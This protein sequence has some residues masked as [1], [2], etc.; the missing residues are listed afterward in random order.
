LPDTIFRTL[1]SSRQNPLASIKEAI[2]AKYKAVDL[3]NELP[4]DEQKDWNQDLAIM[5]LVLHEHIS[6]LVLR[7]TLEVGS[8][9]SHIDP[10]VRRVLI[11]RSFMVD[12]AMFYFASLGMEHDGAVACLRALFEKGEEHGH[13]HVNLLTN[14]NRASE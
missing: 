4:P 10:P 11:A 3:Y 2:D 5:T 1:Q 14:T 8:R 9:L 6:E 12:W 13:P 7:S